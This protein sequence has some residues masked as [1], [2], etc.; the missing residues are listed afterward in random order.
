MVDPSI[1]FPTCM[2]VRVVKLIDKF[3]LALFL[4]IVLNIL[5]RKD[6]YDFGVLELVLIYSFD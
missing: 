4:G 1:C 5:F 6:Y 2:V 3:A